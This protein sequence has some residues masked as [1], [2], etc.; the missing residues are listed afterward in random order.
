MAWKT[1]D[2]MRERRRDPYFGPVRIPEPSDPIA[3]ISQRWLDD[4]A[5]PIIAQAQRE[6][7]LA[8]LALRLQRA[9]VDL[10]EG[11]PAW[12]RLPYALVSSMEMLTNELS[13]LERWLEHGH[14]R[15]C[16][17]EKADY[18]I[19]YTAEETLANPILIEAALEKLA[20]FNELMKVRPAAV[21]LR[22]AEFLKSRRRK[23]EERKQ[24]MGAQISKWL[25]D[26][27]KRQNG[28]AL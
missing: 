22:K 11:S 25:K 14:F 17:Q 3:G 20:A 9:G 15:D 12:H 4:V 23:G 2:W 21:A 5:P 26:L 28:Q 7:E 18:A 8:Q 27:K 10:S 1:P 6:W 13:P 19:G 16:E 24:R